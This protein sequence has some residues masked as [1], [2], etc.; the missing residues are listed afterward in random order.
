[1]IG[2]K[3]TDFFTEAS[4][5]YAEE[6]ALPMFSGTALS[7]RYHINLSR[8]TARCWICF[9]RQPRSG[10]LPAMS[11]ARSRVI[12]DITERKRMEEDL[13]R[14]EGAIPGLVRECIDPIVIVDDKQ[15][16]L[17]VNKRAVSF[18]AIPGR[19]FCR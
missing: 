1:V 2:R 15:N 5:K 3:A 4:R 7:A 9:F 8:R 12:Q 16:Y 10:M 14:S 6:V 19:S 17:D 18:S 11:F 13:L